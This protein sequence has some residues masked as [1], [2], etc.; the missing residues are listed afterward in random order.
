MGISS[1]ADALRELDELVTRYRAR[2]L[3]FVR[4]DFVAR[5]PHEFATTLDWLERYGDRSAYLAAR[6]LRPWL[7]PISNDASAAS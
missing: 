2:C 6:E 4:E 1:Y 5:T 7:L 3:W